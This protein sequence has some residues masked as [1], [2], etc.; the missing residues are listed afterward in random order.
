MRRG[1]YDGWDEK[2]LSTEGDS[3]AVDV[4]KI[5]G[6]EQPNKNTIAGTL[7]VVRLAFSAPKSIAVPADRTPQATLFLLQ[8]LRLVAKSPDLDAQIDAETN[9]VKNATRKQT[10]EAPAPH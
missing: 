6:G 1:A 2:Q 8:Y 10:R 9:F 7:T 4:I 3:A 5:I